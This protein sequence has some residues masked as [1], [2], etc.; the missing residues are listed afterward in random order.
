MTVDRYTKLVLTVIALCLVWLCAASTG[1]PVQAAQR[2][3]GLSGPPQ[4]V[5]IVGW[6]TMDPKGSV[7]VMMTEGRS[8]TVS[9]PN[10]PVKVMSLP[11]DPVAVRL[12]YTDAYPLPVG[13]TSTKRTGEWEPIRVA[14]EGEPVKPRPGRN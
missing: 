5:V 4:P 9:D 11:M 12:E 14:V 13:L 1:W 3:Q 7:S 8:G 2:T 10:I 6:G